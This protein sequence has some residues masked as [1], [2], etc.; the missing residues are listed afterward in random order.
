MKFSNIIGQ[1]S[2]KKLLRGMAD[3]GRMPHALLM[4]GQQGTGGLPLAMAYAQYILCQQKTAEGE[5]CGTCANCVKA[6]KMIHPDIHF[7]YPTVGSKTIATHVLKE[8]RAIVAEN[9]YLNVNQ[10][11]EKLGAENK[12][13]NIPVAEC[14][15]IVKKLSLKTFEASHKIL[16]M[17]LPEYLGKEGNRLLKM[18]E[19]PPD[20]TLFLLVAENQDLILNTVLS[21]CQLVKMSL[22]T[23]EDIKE[24]LILRGITRGDAEAIA[25]LAEGDLNAAM[26]LSK[27]TENDNA[28]LFLEWMR[29]CFKGNGVEMVAWVDRFATI[30]R[31]RQ[32]LFLRYGLHFLR[33]LTV[34]I[35]TG[36][37]NLR[38]RG[39]ELETAKRMKNVVKYP[40]IEPMMTLFNES[41]FHI[42]RNANPKVLFL[43]ASI[44]LNKVL[45]S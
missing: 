11:L 37:E 23:D 12:Q 43:D 8:W 6:E 27:E 32:K 9:P 28:N 19:E 40:H 41:T 36:N 31:E 7:S 45:K 5:S 42:E 13:G 21:R 1:G 2:S 33:E 16:I 44:R 22:L 3:S 35:L 20:D 29:T 39:N 14:V 4:L 10:W 17:W 25:H 38:L 18:I 24:A 15:E 30:G 26:T 34:L